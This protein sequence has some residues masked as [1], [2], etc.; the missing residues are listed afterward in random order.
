MNQDFNFLG[1][2]IGGY[3][4]QDIDF[5]VDSV[6]E[7]ISNF[8]EK[9]D[10]ATREGVRADMKNFLDR[11]HNQADD[12]FARRFGHDFVPAEIG[13][14]AGEFF[15]VVFAILDNRKRGWLGGVYC[16]T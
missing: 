13:Q 8:A 2:M 11:Y 5:E 4:H 14:S 10:A 9:A 6:P 12:E 3:L 15:N 1:Q 16:C 7:A